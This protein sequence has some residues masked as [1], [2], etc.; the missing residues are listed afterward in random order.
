[1]SAYARVFIAIIIIVNPYS[2]IIVHYY[3]MPYK[4]LKSVDGPTRFSLKVTLGKV[5]T[6]QQL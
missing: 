4:E 3:D 6:L 1:M 2:I 5:I